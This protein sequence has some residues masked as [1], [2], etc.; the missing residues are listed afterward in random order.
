[1]NTVLSLEN[2]KGSK[3]AFFHALSCVIGILLFVFLGLFWFKTSL[4]SI[5]LLSISWVILNAYCLDRNVSRLKEGI[6]SAIQQSASVFLIF[7]LIG[8]VIAAFTLSGAIPTL[9]Y[10]GLDFID[11]QAFLPISML[12]CS[13]TSLAIGSCWGTI[14]TVGVALISLASVFHIPLPLAAGAIVSGA[15][16][17]DKFSPISD[18]TILS[19]LS[20]GT[21]LYKHI[22]GMMYTMIPAYL[23]SLGLFGI[24]GG[25]YAMM[26]SP[27]SMDELLAIQQLIANHVHVGLVVLLPIVVMLVLSMK[28]KPAEISMLAAVIAALLVSL[29]CQSIP[30]TESLNALFSGPGV[31]NTG[32]LMVDT[33]LSRGGMQSMLWSMSL[34]L[35]ILALGGLLETYQFVTVLFESLIR[36][37]KRPTSL[38]FMT[39]VT[40][41]VSNLLMG[42]AYLSILL[43]SR[44]YKN[45]FNAM[46]LDSCVLSKSVEEGCTF[47]T[48]LI[49]WSTSGAFIATTIGVCPF[50][51]LFWSIFNW[52]API[53]FLLFVAGNFYGLK[54]FK[55][56]P[57]V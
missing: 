7:I 42:E 11:P 57:V 52:I 36:S 38:V 12:L 16:F 32:S 5:M 48:P 45:A 14:G 46:G 18:T 50:D 15:Y 2:T 22:K 25:H 33:L 34:T 51:Y 26:Q 4:H 49:P 13:I 6:T 29:L 30:L 8:A 19:A 54:M 1:M 9:V 3:P 21:D 41:V 20:T 35:L 43:T 40:S 47:S 53:V 28:K 44:I 39:L 55:T 10:Y 24:I 23:I 27:S 31:K 37:L 56:T 17:G